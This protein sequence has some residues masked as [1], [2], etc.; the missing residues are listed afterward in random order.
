MKRFD[1]HS[2]TD[3]DLLRFSR[4]IFLSK[5]DIAGQ[6]VL[7]NSHVLIVGLGGLGSVAA[8]YLG[9]CGVGRF[10]LL[11]FDR[12]ELSN[13]H[14]QPIHSLADIGKYKTIS[15]KE[16]LMA[17]NSDLVI[18]TVEE[19][20]DTHF[21]SQLIAGVDCV[22]DCSDNFKTRQMVNQACW[23]GKTPL[24]SAAVAG[25]EGQLSVFDSR[26]EQSA[27]YRCLYSD[28]SAADT[29][30]ANG[31]LGPSVGVVGSM[32]SVEV[33]K[34]LINLEESSKLIGK[35][36]LID[37]LCWEIRVVSI[38]KDPVCPVCSASFE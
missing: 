23:L 38:G 21:L 7:K 28:E 31:V 30:S 5:I 22:L 37:T 19:K 9:A 36:M 17:G 34:V 26:D 25:F 18:E 1:K 16:S 24:V 20:V 27:C 32:Q 10:T 15:A 35:L 8:Q 13:L 29:C 11:D 2:L 3:S 33:I 4:Q 14:R 12:V 6:T